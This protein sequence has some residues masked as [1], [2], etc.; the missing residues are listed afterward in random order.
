MLIFALLTMSKSS[1]AQLRSPPQEGHFQF[2]GEFDYLTTSANYSAAG[3]PSQSLAGG[4]KLTNLSGTGEFTYDFSENIRAW[5]GLSGGQSQAYVIDTT[6]ST[7]TN[8]ISDYHTNSGLSQGW[9][10]AQGWWRLGEVDLVPEGDF[11]YPFF[12]VDQTSSNPLLGEGAMRLQAGSW[13]MLHLNELTPFVYGGY[14]YR[15][16][17]RSSLFPYSAGLRY[18]RARTWWLQMQF[19]GYESIVND[20]NTNNRNLR[21]GYLSQADG[22]SYQYF[23]INP[24]HGEMAGQIGVQYA[25]FAIFAGGSFSVYGRSS[26]D[27]W[28]GNVG[29][30]FSGGTRAR[31]SE[32]PMLPSDDGFLM[33][34]DKYDDSVFRESSPVAPEAP[35]APPQQVA[36]PQAKPQS[37]APARKK[38]RKK[39]KKEEPMPNV[40]QLMKD[41]EKT[42]DKKRN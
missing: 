1:F 30:I 11:I 16:E 39:V 14:A 32:A 9:I 6:Y 23:A 5:A 13:L 24:S 22:G 42:L 18:E 3:G 21:D 4:G 31:H 34:P 25:N 15:D 19:Q 35:E 17:G 2:L 27:Y 38:P 40:E 26:A 37:K 10:G 28:S 36:P 8:I 12:R 41:T 29:F 33:K 20:A 7:P